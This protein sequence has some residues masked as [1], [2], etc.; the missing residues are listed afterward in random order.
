[1]PRNLKRYYFV[2]SGI[3]ADG[4]CSDCSGRRRADRD[5]GKRERGKGG[6]GVN[7]A[8]FQ[9]FRR[10]ERSRISFF[11]SGNGAFLSGRPGNLCLAAHPRRQECYPPPS[12][13]IY[14]SRNNSKISSLFYLLTSFQASG[15]VSLSDELEICNCD[16]SYYLL[17]DRFLNNTPP[18]GESFVS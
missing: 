5:Q 7:R 15:T 4:R 3:V 17:S 16:L 10:C 18:S 14:W 11:V 2:R 1:M 13:S 9:P 12:S 8:A 6:S